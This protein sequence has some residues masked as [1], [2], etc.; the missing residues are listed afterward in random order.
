MKTQSNLASNN[1]N[2]HF[3]ISPV[4]NAQGRYAVRDL[5]S[6]GGTFIRIQAG[7]K[8]QLHAGKDNMS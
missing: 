4:S 1:S 3:E 7:Q 8:K 5:G 6:A 2:R